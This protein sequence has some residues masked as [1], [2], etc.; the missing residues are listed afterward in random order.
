LHRRHPIRPTDPLRLLL[1]VAVFAAGGAALFAADQAELALIF[2][3]LVLA[4]LSLT[5]VLGQRPR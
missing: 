4:H 1:E 2:A 3:A 5:F